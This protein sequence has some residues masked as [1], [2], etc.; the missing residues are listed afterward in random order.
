MRP[1]SARVVD[2][3]VLGQ[4]E[5]TDQ[6]TFTF[7]GQQILA[8]ADEVVAAALLAHGIRELRKTD[9]GSAPRGLYCAIG[10]C[11]ECQ[12][13]IDGQPGVRACLTRVRDGMRVSSPRALP[14]PG[15]DEGQAP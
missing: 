1:E 13:T 9:P 14:P 8:R 3:P 15:A 6:I 10:H 4:D 2:H 12:M 5:P 11:Y 7:D